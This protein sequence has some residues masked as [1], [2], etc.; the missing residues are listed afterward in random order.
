M[1]KEPRRIEED[2]ATGVYTLYVGGRLAGEMHHE[3]GVWTANAARHG[4]KPVH[5]FVDQPSACEYLVTVLRGTNWETIAR[6]LASRLLTLIGHATT[7]GDSMVRH[8]DSRKHLWEALAD[9]V[10]LIPDIKVDREKLQILRL[11]KR[12]Q[13]AAFTELDNKRKG[14]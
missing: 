7:P 13:K 8:N 12:Q 5:G 6:T 1:N 3:G 10:E 14:I 9:D 2:R 4:S 11:P